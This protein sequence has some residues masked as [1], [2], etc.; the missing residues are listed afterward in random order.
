MN[1]VEAKRAL[2]AELRARVAAMDPEA[3]EAASAAVR[4]HVMASL[5]WARA[6]VVMVYAADASEPDLDGLIGLGR[7][8]GKTMCV[9]RV[10]WAGKRLIPAAVDSGA[11]LVEDRHAIRVPTEVCVAVAPRAVELVIAPG[12]GFGLDG[13]RLGRGGGFYDRF[14]AERSA[15]GSMRMVVLGACFAAQVVGRIPSGAQD[16]RMNGLVTEAGLVMVTQ[17]TEVADESS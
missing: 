13:A 1:P 17:G 4:G 11:D 14:L 10:D 5:V 8:G 2:R 16:Q 7:A 15:G 3:R 6:R 12:V 9:P